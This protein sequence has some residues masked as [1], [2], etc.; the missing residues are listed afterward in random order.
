MKRLKN[1]SF[2]KIPLIIA[3][4]FLLVACGTTPDTDPDNDTNAT[5][6]IATIPTPTPAPHQGM[7]PAPQEPIQQMEPPDEPIPDLFPPS[8]YYFTLT[9]E[10]QAAY[11][12]L[13]AELTTDVFYGL[14]PISV[15]KI[16][17]QAGIDGEWEA[18]FVAHNAESMERTREEWYEQH[19]VDMLWSDIASRRS[20]ANWVFPFIDDAEVLIDEEGGRALLLFDS[21][22][23]PDDGP[24]AETLHFFHL[25]RSDTGIWEARFR[26][27]SME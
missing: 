24:Y 14:S 2:I 5:E 12:R 10:E 3:G 20:L 8:G 7:M 25:V 15:A 17:I 1:V 11:E 26:W 6:S 16:T 4:C 27:H 13:K 19:R 9:A 23:D 22:P 21:V 18:E